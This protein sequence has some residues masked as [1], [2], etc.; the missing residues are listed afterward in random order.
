MSGLKKK[1]ERCK[2]NN[3][4][5]LLFIQHILVPDSQSSTCTNSFNPYNNSTRQEH[6]CFHFTDEEPGRKQ[7]G[8][9]HTLPN[10]KTRI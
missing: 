9:G 5:Q 1:K 10:D 8:Q 2:K 3:K 4:S 6:G 7:L